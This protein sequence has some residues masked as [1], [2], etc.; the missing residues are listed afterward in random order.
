MKKSFFLVLVFF[1]IFLVLLFGAAF[2][3]MLEENCTH[4]K[5]G[6]NSN[7]FN[8]TFFLN[9][10]VRYLP[11][12]AILSLMMLI[13]Y[14]IKHK[15]SVPQFI[16]PY[17]IIALL[18]WMLG[19]PGSAFLYDN[20]Q[21]AFP[22]VQPDSQDFSAGYFRKDGDF[23]TFVT[24]KEED[25][26]EIW[27]RKVF[28]EQTSSVSQE[29]YDIPEIAENSVIFADS[30]IEKAVSIPA[31]WNFAHEK[32]LLL[33]NVCRSALAKGYLS[34]L[35]FATMGFALSS[36]VFM[37]RFSSWRLVNVLCVIILSTLIV[38]TNIHFYDISIIEKLPILGKWWL[39]LVFNGTI[40]ALFMTVGIINWIH[41]PDRNMED[42]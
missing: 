38:I 35:L 39:P 11:W 13:L 25:D 19:I 26:G 32:C 36:V 3:T 31:W 14:I 20:V 30:L 24:G 12:C 40:C 5:A 8:W 41:H 34:Y 4:M 1:V 15:F 18:L 29:S 10:A 17:Y 37:C 2:F 23:L 33:K 28:S 16:I 21:K 9:S 27:R 42:R 6:I 22:I 7:F